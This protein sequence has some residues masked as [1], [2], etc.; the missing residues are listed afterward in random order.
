MIFIV[1]CLKRC[2]STFGTVYQLDERSQKSTGTFSTGTFSGTFSLF[3]LFSLCGTGSA[4]GKTTFVGI[5][6][7]IAIDR[8]GNRFRILERRL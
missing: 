3:E 7:I 2:P 1:V 6:A 5:A 4:A 8:P